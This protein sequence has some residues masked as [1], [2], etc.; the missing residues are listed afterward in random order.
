MGVSFVTGGVVLGMLERPILT[1]GREEDVEPGDKRGGST[2]SIT[3]RLHV[4]VRTRRRMCNIAWI[5][6][7]NWVMWDE[8]SG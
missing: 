5:T 1:S 4:Q 6:K 7:K 8:K 3:L 2:L